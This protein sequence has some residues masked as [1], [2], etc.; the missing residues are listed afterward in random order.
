MEKNE[1]IR[2]R[3]HLA[4]IGHFGSNKELAMDTVV[5]I[6]YDRLLEKEHYRTDDL[7]D[8]LEVN[9]NL[10]RQAV[11]LGELPA[12]VLDHHIVDIRKDDVVHWLADTE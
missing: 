11:F 8:L 6:N 5:K 7:A 2:V 12:L 3:P 1:S 9:V 10:I 4:K